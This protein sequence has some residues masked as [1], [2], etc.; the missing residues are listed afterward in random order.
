MKNT[1]LGFEPADILL[2]KAADMTKWSVIACDQ[3]T[4]QPEYWD[5][6]YSR[7]ADAPSTLHLILPEAYL[8]RPL[9]KT[10]SDKIPLAM[11]EYLEGDIFKT[12]EN[13]YI[14]VERT[15]RDG[16]VRRGI[17][18][19]LDLEVYDYSKGSK[20]LCRATEATVVERLPKRVEIRKAAQL[21]LPHILMLIDD[22]LNQ[23]IEPY[24]DIKASL[25]KLYDFELYPQSGK[26][27]GWRIDSGRFDI[28]RHGLTNLLERAS[29]KDPM[30]YAIGDGN[31]SLAAAKLYYEQLK[32][33]L[34]DKAKDHPARY[35]LLELVNLRDA[36]LDFEPIHRVVFEVEPEHFIKEFLSY[37]PDMQKGSIGRQNVTVITGGIKQQYGFLN[38]ENKLCAG[39]VQTFLDWYISRF[40][41]RIDYI[42][43]Q[44]AVENIAAG[45]SDRVG[46]LLDDV[47]KSAFFQSVISDGALPR[48]TFS[49][50][51]AW[52]KRFYLE[53]RK[54]VR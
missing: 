4:S 19:A 49:M 48:K 18:G 38:P 16:R 30:L 40:G 33:E 36:A 23:V 35:A 14:Y 26:I 22:D 17:V 24:N 42:H 1:E 25:E 50:G 27:A 43:G 46:L 51:H 39:T 41:G 3:Y 29:D 37:Y 5:D 15:L 8:E 2:P 32:S 28:L 54:I 9:S 45:G 53:C 6:I 13:S 20:S 12:I 31:H 10:I 11:K 21:E 47:D 44:R 34:G 52:D 7:V